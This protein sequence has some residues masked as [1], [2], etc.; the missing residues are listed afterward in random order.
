[1]ILSTGIVSS[2]L[3]L[4]RR[5][6]RDELLG[7]I[8]KL[9]TNYIIKKGYKVGGINENSSTLAV[10]QALGILSPIINQKKK[11]ILEL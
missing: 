5:G 6:I 10:R 1:M 7:K 4:H 3:L 2:V 9:I 11:N 8:V